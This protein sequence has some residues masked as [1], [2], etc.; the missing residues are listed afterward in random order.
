M[1]S[2][3]YKLDLPTINIIINNNKSLIIPLILQFFNSS[4][5]LATV[6]YVTAVCG[7]IAGDHCPLFKY[8]RGL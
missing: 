6:D 2:D 5:D 7:N 4:C 3:T 1:Q 8:T